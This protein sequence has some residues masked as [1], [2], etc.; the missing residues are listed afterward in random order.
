MAQTTSFCY[1]SSLHSYSPSQ[2]TPPI[3]QSL[4]LTPA[5]ALYL[6]N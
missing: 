4:A 6:A 3:R 1:F 5:V 2:Q